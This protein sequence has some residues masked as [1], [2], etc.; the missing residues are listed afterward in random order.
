M[1]V[2]QIAYDFDRFETK[3]K[4]EE[5]KIQLKS[6]AGG[7]SKVSATAKVLRNIRTTALAIILVVA[8]VGLLQSRAR[9]TELSQDIQTAEKN[10]TV[11]QNKNSY[12]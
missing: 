11:E 7:K 6:V 9:I 8:C 10:L 3:Q 12:L 2:A 4:Q 5:K 1:L